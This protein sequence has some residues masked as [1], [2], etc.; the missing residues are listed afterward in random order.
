MLNDLY[1]LLYL[2]ERSYIKAGKS[3]HNYLKFIFMKN[4]FILIVI[5]AQYWTKC[6]LYPFYKKMVEK[7]RWTYFN[8]EKHFKISLYF[9]KEK[10]CAW[11][12]RKWFL[13][14]VLH[15]YTFLAF[16]G[17]SFVLVYVLF[18]LRIDH[19]KNSIFQKT[20]NTFPPASLLECVNF[21]VTT[22]S[23]T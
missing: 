2:I 11:I 17:T 9:P 3:I 23:A 14:S 12:K 10:Y 22:F 4:I 13:K 1:L 20:R 15:I 5:M 6:F 8:G 7:W 19:Q 21:L 16:V 18:C